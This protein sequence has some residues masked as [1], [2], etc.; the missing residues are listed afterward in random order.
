MGSDLEKDLERGTDAENA[1]TRTESTSHSAVEK[2]I[3]S[4]GAPD[5]DHEEVEQ[6]DLGRLDDLARQQVSPSIQPHSRA[7]SNLLCRRQLLSK[8]VRQ[9]APTSSIFHE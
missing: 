6:M 9:K 8:P 4:V 3:T 2:E 5:P 1:T 7:S